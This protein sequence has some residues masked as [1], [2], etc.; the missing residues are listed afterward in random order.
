MTN[1]SEDLICAAVDSAEEIRDP[2]F[3][4][5]FPEQGEHLGVL[6]DLLAEQAEHLNPAPVSFSRQSG[7]RLSVSSRRMQIL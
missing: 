2:L 5:A 3:G 4:G 7:N 6:T 1:A